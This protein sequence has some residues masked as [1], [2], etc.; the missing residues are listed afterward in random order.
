MDFKGGDKCA[1]RISFGH[2]KT[3]ALITSVVYYV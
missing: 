2:K 1:F 3:E